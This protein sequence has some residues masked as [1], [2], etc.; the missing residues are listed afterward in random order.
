[1]ELTQL[2]SFLQIAQSGSMTRAA[3][4]LCLTQPAITQHI[5]ALEH[6]L[7]IKLFDR[8][9]RGMRMTPAGE[10]LRIYA[11][12]CLASL[13]ECRLAITELEAGH[14][15]KL[16]IGAGVTT[17]IF[18]LPDWLRKFRS[19]YPDIEV[20]IRTGRSR[21]IL[22]LLKDGEIDLGIITTPVDHPHLSLQP[23]FVE[24]IILVVPPEHPF[25]NESIHTERLVEVP[26]ILFPHGNGFRAYLDQALIQTGMPITV[27]METDSVEAIK[28]FVEAGLGA[29]FLPRSA[30]QEELSRGTLAAIVLPDIAP[31]QRTT[32]LAYQ[33]N[34][35]QT[36]SVRHFLHLLCSRSEISEAR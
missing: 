25:A 3:D 22:T 23:L 34:R 7:G 1:M 32:Y 28:R 9:P 33:S 11:Q 2:R 15:G 13:E 19:N 36:F 30:V 35:Y 26:L 27:K 29:S 17:S 10:L 14:V 5:Q 21:E 16:V 31:L 18:V 12:R 4:S 6:E 8:Y 20:I 24:D